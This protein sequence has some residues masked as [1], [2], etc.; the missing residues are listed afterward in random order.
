MSRSVWKIPY[1][2]INTPTKIPGNRFTIY[3]R[4]ATITP[5]FIGKTISI[6]NGNRLINITITENHVG[7]KFGQ[8]ALTKKRVFHKK[9]EK[10]K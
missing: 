5:Y 8:F 6:H 10:R 7:F 4:T 1:L 2:L 9:K 3:E